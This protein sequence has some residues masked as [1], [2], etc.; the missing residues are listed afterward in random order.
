VARLLHQMD[1]S[2]RVNYKILPMDS[3]PDRDEQY[4][5]ISRLRSHFQHQHLPIISMDTNKRELVGD[6]K[7]PG[8][9]WDRSPNLCQK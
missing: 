3:S 9:R 4:D 5:Y 8:T 7:N 1:Y 6:F 2:L